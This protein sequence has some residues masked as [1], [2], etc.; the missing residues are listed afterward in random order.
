MVGTRGESGSGEWKWRDGGVGE[1][2]A[3]VVLWVGVAVVCGRRRGAGGPVGGLTRLLG[4]RLVGSCWWLV[5]AGSSHS[6]PQVIPPS[7]R[8]HREEGF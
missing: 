8:A 2:D 1:V 4:W 7:T 3:G 6:T 5:V